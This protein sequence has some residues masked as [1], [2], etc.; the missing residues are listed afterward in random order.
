[1][2]PTNEA[3]PWYRSTIIIS[4]VISLITKV[5]VVSG[6]VSEITPHDQQILSNAV[7]L[8]LGGIADIVAMHSRATQ[9]AAP[10]VVRSK[11]KA[12]AINN[13]PIEDD[14]LG[15]PQAQHVLRD[16]KDM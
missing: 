15:L 7:I 10:K 13:P 16:I 3:M 1:M 5:L 11:K 9:K 12:E 4:A 8:I 6:L 14:A 2:E